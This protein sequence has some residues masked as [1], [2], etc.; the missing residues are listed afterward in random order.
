MRKEHK[1]KTGGLT[2]A[3]RRYFKRTQGSNLKAKRGSKAAKR[4]K[5]FCARMRGMRKRQ[6][7]SNNTGKDRLSL[8]L[9]KWKC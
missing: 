7:P 9:K 5:S 6:K 8:S 1:S 4:R 2:A 3:G